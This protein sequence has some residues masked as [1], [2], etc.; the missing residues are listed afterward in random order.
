MK[1]YKRTK[2]ESGVELTD[3]VQELIVHRLVD[4]RNMQTE[5]KRNYV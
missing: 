5:L 2:E 4:N 3:A 1:V